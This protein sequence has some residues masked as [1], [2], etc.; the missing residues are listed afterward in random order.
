[1]RTFICQLA[2][3]Q[4]ELMTLPLIEAHVEYLRNLKNEGK[5]PFCGPCVDG[6]ALMILTVDNQD[7][8]VALMEGDPFSKVNYYRAEFQRQNK[9]TPEK[10]SPRFRKWAAESLVKKTGLDPKSDEFKSS[11][12]KILSAQDPQ[13][14]ALGSIPR[15][16][17]IHKRL[18]VSV[19]SY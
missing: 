15:E 11:V 2:D 12:E 1:M 13:S 3:K 7:E 5:L 17:F 6:T 16:P 10:L 14:R 18:E 8:A 4:K 19:V 9:S